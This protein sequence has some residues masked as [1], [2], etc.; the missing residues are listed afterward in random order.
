MV[1]EAKRGDAVKAMVYEATARLRDPVYGTAGIIFHLQKMVDELKSQLEATSAQVLE[2]KARR[3]QLQR[4]LM[5][6]H[7]LDIVPAVHVDPLFDACCSTLSQEYDHH[8]I[9]YDH[10]SFPL[11]HDGSV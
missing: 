4:N 11:H 7:S 3:D 2:L 8:T 10:I 6:V 5:N 9:A 1:E